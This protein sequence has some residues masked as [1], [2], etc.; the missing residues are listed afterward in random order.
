MFLQNQPSDQQEE[1]VRLLK[2][3]GGLSN[4]FSSNKSPYLPYRLHEN[5]FAKAL[6]ASNESRSDVSVDAVKGKTGI[7]LK[8]FL[9][10]NSQYEK[11]AEFNK[12]LPE[13]KNLDPK[14]QIE[15]IAQ[16]RNDRL[17]AT[18][19]IY[20]LDEIMYHCVS[21]AN[22]RFIMFEEDMDLIDL[23][24]MKIDKF[25]DGIINFHDI[26]N[27]YK[28]NVSKS[29]LQKKFIPKDTFEFDVE[30]H[31]D[32][33][34]LLLGLGETTGGIY[35]VKSLVKKEI[36]KD[37]NSIILP[38][39]STKG[40]LRVPQRSGLNQWNALGRPRNP[41]EV[42]VPIPIWIHKVFDG[43]FPPKDQ[44]FELKLP[45]DDSISVRVC[46][47]KGKALMSK[48]NSDLGEWLLRTVLNI[49]EGMLVT[50]EMLAKINIDSVQIVKISDILYEIDFKSL[51]SFE[52]FNLSYNPKFTLK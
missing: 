22:G 12:L 24:S 9:F 41:N 5:I 2:L 15:F 38:L 19:R 8:T 26:K 10:K 14:G 34:E 29:T 42:Y 11:V 3:V 32:P 1:Y 17:E 40:D 39:Y 28:F 44:P 37:Q 20:D 45:G 4:L 49:P 16:A 7:G 6:E 51:G 27:K 21:R 13:Y 36:I 18:M 50:Y 31:N 48:P 25:T 33:Y 52:D 47:A 35:E 43:F 46:Q 30:I 23:S